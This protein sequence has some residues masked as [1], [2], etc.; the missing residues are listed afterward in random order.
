MSGSASQ[1]SDLS[2]NSEYPHDLQPNQNIDQVISNKNLNRLQTYTVRE[3]YDKKSRSS[4]FK[5][6]NWIYSISLLIII[7]I[8]LAF[9]SVTPIDVIIQTMNATNAVAIKTFIVIAVCVVFILFSIIIYFTRIY[10]YKISMNDIPNKSIYIPYKNDYPKVVFEYIEKSLNKCLET[11]KLAGP[12]H[13]KN[14]IINHPGLS[15]PE[16]IKNA[17]NNITPLLPPSIHYEDV[18]GSL[19]DKFYTGKILTEDD[20]PINL[21]IKEIIIYLYKQVNHDEKEVSKNAPNIFKLI[22]LYEKLRFGSQLITDVDLFQFMLEFDK[23]AT[24]CQNDYVNQ[25]P[26]QQ[27]V[28]KRSTIYENNTDNNYYSSNIFYDDTSSSIGI[29]STSSSS[30]INT[31]DSNLNQS[32]T[33]FHHKAVENKYF[34]NIDNNYNSL[35]DDDKSVKRLNLQKQSSFNSSRSVVRN[36]LALNSKNSLNRNISGYITDSEQEEIDENELGIPNMDDEDDDS[37]DENFYKLKRMY[38]VQD[39]SPNDSLESVEITKKPNS[40]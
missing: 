32:E 40:D 3:N 11:A 21:S 17:N 10:Q 34:Q 8:M 37:T 26:Q 9:I 15:P 30:T 36:K 28:N 16:Y 24:M 2:I 33:S 12:L 29:S 35:L 25:M 23:F 31:L 22:T 7:L 14:E 6:L 1:R 5:M 13:Q 18:I 39:I 27:K 4:L 19:G 20:I 38:E